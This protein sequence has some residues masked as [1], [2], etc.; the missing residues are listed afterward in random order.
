MDRRCQRHGVA[1]IVRTDTCFGYIE[2]RQHALASLDEEQSNESK[3]TNPPVDKNEPYYG[4]T[5][6]FSWNAEGGESESARANH[7][8]GQRRGVVSIV[9]TDTSSNHTMG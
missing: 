5:P 1:S 7:D 9:R 8:L 2:K 4:L 6:F 3:N